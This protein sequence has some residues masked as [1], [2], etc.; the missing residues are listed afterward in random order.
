MLQSVFLQ[1][2]LKNKPFLRPSEA[3]LAVSL[4]L[5]SQVLQLVV[6]DSSS[7]LVNKQ[8]YEKNEEIQK[9]IVVIQIEGQMKS[10]EALMEDSLQ[11][12]SLKEERLK[13]LLQEGQ[14]G[15]A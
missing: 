11:Q 7:F 15:K 8:A 5:H 14:K 13:Q 2:L 12:S 10:F 4:L 9:D 1:T 6:Q 3:E